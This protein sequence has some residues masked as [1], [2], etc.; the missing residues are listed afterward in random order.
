MKMLVAIRVV[1]FFLFEKEEIKLGRFTG[2]FGP[3]GSGKSTLLDAAQIALFGADGGKIALNAQ[4]DQGT[5]TTRSIRSY[6][7]GQYGDASDQRQRDAA[8]TFVTLVFRDDR[9][10]ELLSCGVCIYASAAD[11][12]CEIMGRYVLPGLELQLDDHL[13][14]DGSEE[15]PL[16]WSTFRVMVQ[17]RLGRDFKG[18]FLDSAKEY[19]ETLL[20]ALRGSSGVASSS[21]FL[22]AMR[23]SLR[24]RF[25]KSVDAIVR[26]DV[27]ED[28]P[29]RIDKFRRV[30]ESFENLT[31]LV[32]G[33]ED[34]IASAEAVSKD[35][36]KVRVLRAKATNWLALGRAAQSEIASHNLNVVIEAQHKAEDAQEEAEKKK[37]SVSE[38]WESADR[39]HADANA[40]M[41]AHASHRDFGALQA[42]VAAASSR[43]Q[44]TE[45]RLVQAVRLAVNALTVAARSGQLSR[46]VIAPLEDAAAGLDTPTSALTHQSREG[47]SP[48]LA[49]INK[50]AS[51]ALT[52]MYQLAGS[53]SADE[54]R[55]RDDLEEVKRSV[56]SARSGKIRLDER[57][58]RLQR[59][60]HD[61]S[62]STTPVCELV[63]VS[64]QT[65]QGVIESYLG[66]NVQALFVP[67]ANERKAYDIYRSLKGAVT[68]VKVAMESRQDTSIVPRRGSVAELI[69]GSDQRAVAFIRSLLGDLMCADSTEEAFSFARSLTRDGMLLA[70]GDF[71]RI[72]IKPDFQLLLGRSPTDRIATYERRIKELDSN[73][74]EIQGKTLKCKQLIESLTLVGSSNYVTGVLDA[75]DECLAVRSEKQSLESQLAGQA[76]EDYHRLTQ[77]VAHLETAKRDLADCKNKWVRE[78]TL[79]EAAL[80]A[81]ARDRIVVE[82]ARQTAVSMEDE[83]RSAPGFDAARFESRWDAL[84]EG[85]RGRLIEMVSYCE[86][87]HRDCLQAQN[88]AAAGAAAKL[89]EFATQHKEQI[90]HDIL[91]DWEKAGDWLEQQLVRLRETDLVSRRESMEL[92]YQTAKETFRMDVALALNE[93][94]DKL[95]AAQKTLNAALGSCPEF[96][97][98]ERYEFTR[99]L[100]KDKEDLYRFIKEA[101]RVGPQNDLLGGPGDVPAQFLELLSQRNGE[102]GKGKPSALEDYREFFDF[103]IDI[104]RR[105]PAS[106]QY[107]RIGQLSKRLGSGSGGEHR[108]P[109]YVIA[110]AA[111][112]SAYRMIGASDGIGLVM[113]DEV[114]VKMDMSNIIATMRYFDQLG[115]QV[116]MSGPGDNQALLTAFLDRY[117]DILRDP[118]ENAILLSG[119]D[120]TPFMRELA[121][122]DLYEF[123]PALLE[124]EL[125]AMTG[126]AKAA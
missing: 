8:T 49:P 100:R 66:R 122:S 109:L 87:Q 19:L 88:R 38:D 52:E 54:Q 4:S 21:A 96:S 106:G 46:K 108:A 82:E 36:E 124:R 76:D 116:L 123:H 81:L 14:R 64:D 40:Q 74:R 72:R 117:Y 43:L 119:H 105:N 23:F 45:N 12:K 95:E 75:L 94:F 39:Q 26:N 113:L 44:T 1:Q 10:G 93:R 32:K 115:L 20:F 91:Q 107:E 11:T 34:K 90:P 104:K 17:E 114:F 61:K 63:S 24:L 62:I 83:A 42:R 30:M 77:R 78:C 55:V 73:L 53:L 67:M 112:A 41:Q 7:L 29:T 50:A 79:A 86:S 69:T 57:V 98:G 51:S 37:K 80:T 48:L 65:W 126:E 13:V 5:A 35:H 31:N 97:N 103:E 6:C 60:F 121:R 125:A 111:M 2:I 58:E 118:V 15:R 110:G 18:A 16:E 25:D 33:V 9:T 56:D 70:R 99:H 3:N 59:E 89:Q 28:D 85:Y 120:V 47:L 101:A 71:E 27:L 102:E 92:A 22:R 84:L 68:G